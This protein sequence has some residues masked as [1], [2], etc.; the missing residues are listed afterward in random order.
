MAFS[1]SIMAPPSEI[2]L[3][4]SP[5][6]RLDI[7]DVNQ[8]V[9]QKA[10]SF[11]SHYEHALYCS[12]HTTAGFLEQS[13]CDRLGQCQDSVQ[14]FFELFQELFPPEANYQH[15]QMHLRTEL[16]PEQRRTEPRNADSHLTF[17]GAGVE[18]CVTYTSDPQR[19]V[20]FIDLDGINRDHNNEP[21]RRRT[22]V[23]GFNDEQPMDRVE[24]SVPVSNHPTDSISLRD[25]RLGLFDQLHELLARYGITK[26]RVDIELSSDERHAGLTVNEYETLLMRHDLA[27]VLYDPLRFMARKGRNM[28]R[29]PGSIPDKAKNYAKY[30]LVRVMNAF[31]DTLGLSESLVERVLNKFL[32][33]P[34]EHFLRMKRSV[35]LLVSEDEAN[36][37]GTIVQGRYQSPILVQWRRAQAQQRRLKVTL[38]RFE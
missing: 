21:R 18:N 12:H 31:F 36:G 34:A 19:P 37:Q 9:R 5:Q 29:E 20:Y 16:S 38:V 33:L 22:T 17:I 35:S 15:D 13:L 11:L 10:S 26:G 27:E 25:P 8:Y 24:L 6:H 2:E 7:I 23:I 30:D 28:L 32:A 4:F 3:E 14:N 1:S